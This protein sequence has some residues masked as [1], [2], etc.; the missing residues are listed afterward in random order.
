LI[1]VIGEKWV[2][3]IV[4]DFAPRCMFWGVESNPEHKI[5]LQ[6]QGMKLPCVLPRDLGCN[7]L[8]C[9][10]WAPHV[11][12]SE[13]GIPQNEILDRKNMETHMI[14]TVFE[15][16]PFSQKLVFDLGIPKASS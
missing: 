15:G 6:K 12:L 14:D 9:P 3:V 13:V 10:L 2:I 4:A 11:S 16:S 7:L 5:L 1:A 8:G